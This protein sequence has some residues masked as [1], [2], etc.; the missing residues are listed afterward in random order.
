MKTVYIVQATTGEFSD[1]MEWLVAAYFDIQQA[2]KHAEL[3]SIRAE[4]LMANHD[5]FY[6]ILGESNQYD[7]EMSV[8][9]NG[10]HYYVTEL[11]IYHDLL[12]FKLTK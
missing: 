2:K 3:A 12:E 8:D 10:V 6:D 5:N 11:K 1:R 4:E 7:P 9:Y